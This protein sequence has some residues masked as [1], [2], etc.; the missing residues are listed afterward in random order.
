MP[1]A[2]AKFEALCRC[3]LW[4][5]LPPIA[6]WKDNGQLATWVGDRGNENMCKHKAQQTIECHQR[7]KQR[8]SRTIR[9]AG[10]VRRTPRF[11]CPQTRFAESPDDNRSLSSD[12]WILSSEPFGWF[13]PPKSTWAWAPTLLWNHYTKSHLMPSCICFIAAFLA[14]VR[15]SAWVRE[16]GLRYSAQSGRAG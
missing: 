12:A 8:N 1:A 6:H 14:F 10:V 9:G 11:P 13:A 16:A 2:T 7:R 4:E 3:R 5:T 15:P